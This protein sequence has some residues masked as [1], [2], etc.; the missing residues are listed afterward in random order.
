MR[1]IILGGL[2]FLMATPLLAAESDTKKITAKEGY[3]LQE[4][5]GKRCEEAFKKHYP[6]ESYRDEKGDQ[7][8]SNYEAHYNRKLNKCFILVTSNKFAKD[9]VYLDKVLV[10]VNSNMSSLF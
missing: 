7:W 2:L 8:L 4:R 1:A 10:D 3:E 5:C 6:G 9:D